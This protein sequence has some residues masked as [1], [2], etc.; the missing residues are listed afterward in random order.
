MYMYCCIFRAGFVLSSWPAA[1]AAQQ[2]AAAA[3]ALP[4]AARAHQR[5]R[6]AVAENAARSL[7]D[8]WA[9]G[10]VVDALDPAA[11]LPMVSPRIALCLLHV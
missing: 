9:R 3:A 5:Q 6:V 8:A 4:G 11:V 7:T 2:A 1:A 10:L